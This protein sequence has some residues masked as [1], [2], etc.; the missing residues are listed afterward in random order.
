M[1]AVSSPRPLPSRE[2]GWIEWL[3]PATRP[4]YRSF[5]ENLRPLRVIGEGRRGKGEM[6]LG[7]PGTTPDFTAPLPPVFAYGAIETDAGMISIT[8]REMLNDQVSVEIVSHRSDD[9]PENFREI[10]RYSYSEWM[11]GKPCPACGRNVREVSMHPAGDEATHFV[12][13]LCATDRRIWVH[14]PS[15]EVNRLI[16]V[17]NFHNELVLHKNIRDPNVALDS[18]RLFA[19]LPQYSDADLTYA[20]RTYNTLRTKVHVEGPM[21]SDRKPKSSLLSSLRSL[22]AKKS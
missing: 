7:Q 21:E 6:I 12:L 9:I 2:M 22:F 1:E 11:P 3:F 17:T 5:L 19:D 14:D 18:K 10:R 8:V 4:G 16:P 15:S 13:A 20:F